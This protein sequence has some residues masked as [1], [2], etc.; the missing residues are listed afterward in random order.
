VL[1]GC[2]VMPKA[3]S[4]SIKA[5]LIFPAAPFDVSRG[6]PSLLLAHGRIGQP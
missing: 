4:R 3:K 5:F 1:Y 2:A 6:G